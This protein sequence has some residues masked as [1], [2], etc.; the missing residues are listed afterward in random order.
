MAAQIPDQND[1]FL[2]NSKNANFVFHNQGR[3]VGIGS[4]WS[5]LLILLPFYIPE[6]VVILFLATQPNPL[7]ALGNLLTGNDPIPPLGA[8]V[9]IGLLI[10]YIVLTLIITPFGIRKALKERRTRGQGQLIYGK[11]SNYKQTRDKSNF[12]WAGVDY[13]FQSPLTGR[14]I[15]DKIDKFPPSA[16]RIP[17]PF[18]NGMPCALWFIDDETYYL[19]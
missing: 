3:P 10:V 14:M 1:I 6:L 19:L 17:K 5:T 11:V 4:Y 13:Q 7:P 12:E 16:I 8:V 9:K 15:D 18:E 2:L